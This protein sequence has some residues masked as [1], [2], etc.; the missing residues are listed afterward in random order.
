MIAARRVDEIAEHRLADFH[1][2]REQAFDALFQ[3]LLAESWIALNPRLNR[4][5]EILREWHGWY[6]FVGGAT[7]R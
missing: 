4:F 1:L 3:K 2:A 6:S 7:A 5:P